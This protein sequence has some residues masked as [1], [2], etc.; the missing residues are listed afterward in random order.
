MGF[1]GPVLV[2]QELGLAVND[3]AIQTGRFSDQLKRAELFLFE[4]GLATQQ[5]DDPVRVGREEAATDRRQLAIVERLFRRAAATES[6][7]RP[8]GRQTARRFIGVNVIYNKYW[9]IFT[10]YVGANINPFCSQV[11]AGLPLEEPP[12][13]MREKVLLKFRKKAG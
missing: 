4:F 6:E 8:K 13:T 7:T 9:P 12:V 11:L 2:P 5:I 10:D 3:A 1:T